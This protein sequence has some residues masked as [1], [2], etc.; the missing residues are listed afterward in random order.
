MRKIWRPQVGCKACT[1]GSS[2]TAW[3]PSTMRQIDPAQ[4][5]HMAR[6]STSLGAGVGGEVDL[7]QLAPVQVRVN[8]RGR[9][10]GMPQDLLQHAQV[11]AAGE[12][13]RRE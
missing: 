3:A 5:S 12:Q 10:I 11:G 13:V 8:L 9:D 2:R 7:L 6:W 1:S 4:L